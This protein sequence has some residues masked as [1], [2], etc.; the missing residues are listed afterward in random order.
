MRPI[1]SIALLALAQSVVLPANAGSPC[2]HVGPSRTAICVCSKSYCWV[3][4]GTMHRFD[5]LFADAKA[6]TGAG[7]IGL[8]KR[9]GVR[10][11]SCKRSTRG[12]G[13]WEA[14]TER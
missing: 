3:E 11:H 7:V 1:W 14:P 6:L 4:P 8:W 12:R 13:S 5:A 9:V 10:P 2:G